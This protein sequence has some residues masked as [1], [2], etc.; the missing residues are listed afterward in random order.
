MHFSFQRGPS[1]T[2]VSFRIPCYRL[3]IHFRS[4]SIRVCYFLLSCLLD[5]LFCCQAVVVGCL[6]LHNGNRWK[7]NAHAQH[8][9]SQSLK[10]LPA[11]YESLF[12]YFGY[13]QNFALSL[14]G[15]VPQGSYLLQLNLLLFLSLK[16]SQFSRLYDLKCRRI[17]KQWKLMKGNHLIRRSQDERIWALKC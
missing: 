12:I 10:S 15:S 11:S 3:L 8:A 13:K 14:Q 16:F 17:L 7:V 1:L 4:L 5:L 2:I 6:K 9:V